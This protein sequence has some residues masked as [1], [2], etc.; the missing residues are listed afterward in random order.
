MDLHGPLTH[1]QIHRNDFVRLTLNDALHYLRFPRGQR[2]ETFPDR[3]SLQV[4]GAPLLVPAQGLV[5]TIEQ[6][7]VA[8]RLLDEV[9]RTRLHRANRHRDVA[10]AGDEYEGNGRTALVQFGL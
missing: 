7:L 10:V 3:Q 9:E 4:L 6:I 5:N 1:A 2:C 8:K